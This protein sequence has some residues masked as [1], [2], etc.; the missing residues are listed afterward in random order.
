MKEIPFFILEE[1]NEAFFLWNYAVRNNLI[2]Q[3]G[4][5]L[6]HVDEHSDMGVPRFHHSIKSLNGSLQELYKFTYSEITIENFIVAA[7][8]QGLFNKVYWLYQSNARPLPPT[9]V[10][11]SYDREGKVLMAKNAQELGTLALF[12]SEYRN[13]EFQCMRVGN[14]FP[15]SQSFVLDIDLDYFSCNHQYHQ[16]KGQVEIT[17]DEYNLFIQDKY[18]FLRMLLGSGVKAE[19]NNGKYYLFFNAFSDEDIPSKL[20]VSEKEIL[21]RIDALVEFLKDKNVQPQLID[22]CRSR[23]SGFTPE[24]QWR[25]I[26][27]TLIEKISTLYKLEINSISE[28]YTRENL[29]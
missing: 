22:I 5:T 11:Y 14:D 8:Y 3:S 12:D 15:E 16:F 26:E 7:I 29:G 10:V 28:I 4:N 2:K 27:Q 19:I 25:F 6:L 21:R 9:I 17:K 20:K 13:V 23:L 18:H 1:H 24:E